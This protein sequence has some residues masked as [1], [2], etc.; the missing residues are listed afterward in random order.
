MRNKLLFTEVNDVRLSAVFAELTR[1]PERLGR[2]LKTSLLKLPIG[3][4]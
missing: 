1:V 3:E 4:A 2:V